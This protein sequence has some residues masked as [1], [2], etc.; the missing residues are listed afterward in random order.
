MKKGNYVIHVMDALNS[1]ILIEITNENNHLYLEAFAKPLRFR[2][3]NALKHFWCVF[4]S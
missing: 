1:L 4:G 2:K 3:N